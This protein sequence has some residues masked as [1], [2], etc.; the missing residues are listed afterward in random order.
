MSTFPP[1]FGID[2]E[3]WRLYTCS[4]CHPDN[5]DEESGDPKYETAYQ[6]VLPFEKI[7][8]SEGRQYNPENPESACPIQYCP[9]CGGYLSLGADAEVRVERVRSR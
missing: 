2:H 1:N 9:R 3:R 5:Y 8:T 7:P 6:V 4:D